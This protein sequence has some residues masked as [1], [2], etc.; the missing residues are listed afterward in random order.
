MPKLICKRVTFYS[1]H[2]ETVF[3]EWLSKIQGVC[4]VKG[5]SDEIHVFVPRSVISDTCLRELTALFYRYKIDMQQLAQFVN[6][7]NREWYTGKQKYWHNR[8]FGKPRKA[9]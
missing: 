9:I 6:E 1:C 3:F 2:D 4:K 7:K 5:E 8:V